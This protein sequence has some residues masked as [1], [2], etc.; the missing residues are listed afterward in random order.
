M[1]I[2]S[3]DQFNQVN[4]SETTMSNSPAS[5]DAKQTLIT[6]FDNGET[7]GL[8][9]A[10]VKELKSLGI[11][12][13]GSTVVLIE[14]L[15]DWIG[16]QDT[17]QL[18]T[19]AVKKQN[20]K[21]LK[22]IIEKTADA[23]VQ[24]A[25]KNELKT[26][27]IKSEL[28]VQ[29]K[30]VLAEI[31]QFNELIA[32]LP[33]DDSDVDELT[34]YVILQ[35]MKA[36]GLRQDIKDAGN[37]KAQQ[38][39]AAKASALHTART[40]MAAKP[41]SPRRRGRLIVEN[42]TIKEQAIETA[43]KSS[44]VPAVKLIIENNT[45]KEQVIEESIEEDEEVVYRKKQALIDS[46]GQ[47]IKAVLRKTKAGWAWSLLDSDSE[48]TG[49]TIGADSARQFNELSLY[50]LVQEA[51]EVEG[52]MIEYQDRTTGDWK[53]RFKRSQLFPINS[54]VTTLKKLLLIEKTKGNVPAV[55]SIAIKKETNPMRKLTR[56]TAATAAPK[57]SLK[58]LMKKH[59]TQAAPSYEVQSDPFADYEEEETAQPS[60]PVRKAKRSVK[61]AAPALNLNDSLFVNSIKEL[62]NMVKAQSLILDSLTSSQATLTKS[63]DML[64][65]VVLEQSNSI[66]TL[67]ATIESVCGDSEEEVQPVQEAKPAVKRKTAPKNDNGL[68]AAAQACID[69]ATQKST[70]EDSTFDLEELAVF[71]GM[72]ASRSGPMKRSV[73]G[74]V[75][76]GLL[77]VYQYEDGSEEY[78]LP[79]L[80]D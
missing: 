21:A 37:V 3:V 75:K 46:N 61:T 76:K 74:C 38:H 12:Q 30:S 11:N 39:K 6:Q 5:F 48:V 65:N 78:G 13:K 73:S 7:K 69:L 9:W 31:E 14:R 56:R 1:V 62:M 66:A 54:K 41:P 77:E 34:T 29:L 80:A 32:S 60:K 24:A 70:E 49:E 36:K 68:S 23:E 64:S 4:E 50:G 63:V 59:K 53:R 58:S 40:A 52:S 33:K 22:K 51:I 44:P 43:K 8:Y 15:R 35:G 26:Y 17:N 25:A 10:L 45:I 57:K 19:K 47:L 71:R 18:K 55:N 16:A 72:D 79:G 42:N 2:G 27:G 67:K 28:N 20:K